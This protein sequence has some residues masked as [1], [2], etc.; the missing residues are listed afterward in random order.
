[1]KQ[2]EQEAVPTATAPAAPKVDQKSSLMWAIA[3]AARLQGTEID[4]LQLHAVVT[5]HASEID[6]IETGLHDWNTVLGKLADELDIRLDAPTQQPDP[7]RLPA[8]VWHAQQGWILIRNQSASGSWVSQD[9]LD[10]WSEI[11]SA[12]AVN[13]VRMHFANESEKMSDN[14]S[15]HF[16][17]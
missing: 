11:T 9:Y 3:Q 6:N 14:P 12:T 4:R 2:E 17:L 1:M 16:F 7:A 10:Q 8:I 15:F 5:Q 13:C